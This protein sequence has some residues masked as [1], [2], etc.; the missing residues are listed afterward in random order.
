ML[1]I[2]RPFKLDDLVEIDSNFGSIKEIGWIT[3]SIETIEGQLVFV[4]NQVIYNNTFTNYSKFN[5]R[6]VVLK[7]GVSYGDDLNHVKEVA[8]NE[9]SKIDSLLKNEVV[10]FY[11]TSIGNSTYNF[12]IRFWIRFKY[13]KD[14]LAALSEVITRIKKRFEDENISISYPVTTLDFGVKGGINIFDE[15]VKVQS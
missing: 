12:E 14:Y 9:V 15:A 3:T 8:L 5:K 7:S 13:Q 11:F 10:D 2:Q 1:N 6:L 4:P